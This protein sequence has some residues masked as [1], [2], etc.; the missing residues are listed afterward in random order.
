VK[1][2][3]KKLTPP[4]KNTCNCVAWF[5]A[6]PLQAYEIYRTLP[7]H[8]FTLL[9]NFALHGYGIGVLRRSSRVSA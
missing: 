6:L 4:K 7:I 2:G 1:I 5:C 8:L 3:N 9:G